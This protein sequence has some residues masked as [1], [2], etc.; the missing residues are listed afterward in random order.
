VTLSFRARISI[1]LVV[2][3]ILPVAAAA[4]LMW[5]TGAGGSGSPG[6]AIDRVVLFGLILAGFVGLTLALVLTSILLEPLKD[7]VKAVEQVSDGEK[8]TRIEVPGEDELALLADRYNRLAADLDLRDRELDRVQDEIAKTDPTIGATRLAELAAAGAK[9]AFDMTSAQFVLGNPDDLPVTD[10]VPGEPLPIRAVL[11]LGFEEFGALVGTLAPSRS[12]KPSD[13]ALLE[14][15]VTEIAFAIRNAELIDRV[16]RQNGRLRD[17]D[18]AKDEF[19]RGVGHNLQTPLTSIRASAQQLIAERP[20]QRLELIDEQAGRLSRMVR[21]L[22]T[23]SRLD[24]GT[25]KA[26]PDVLALGPRATRAWEAL[27]AKG[28][29]FEVVDKAPGWLAVADPDQLDQVLWALLDNAVSHGGKSPVQ[30]RIVAEAGGE[31]GGGAANADAGGDAS[32]D[33]ASTAASG[34]ASRL[35]LTVADNGPGIPEADRERLFGRY[36]QLGGADQR[37][38][39]GLGLY[40]S[41]ELCRAMGGD[42]VLEP[43]AATD[44]AGAPK[45]KTASKAKGRA[46]TVASAAPSGAAFTVSLPAEP[47]TGE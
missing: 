7:F 10:R 33:A 4:F 24:S 46:G 41:R 5:A 16:E 28:V 9:A 37:G 38:G 47:P 14:L 34:A 13:Q 45:P 17:L 39:T 26:R 15:Y 19:L 42:L 23:V 25:V 40:V 8:R 21:Q 44:K 3:A 6:S 31:D 36:E 35:L 30:V 1:A 22:V 2:A 20:D 11:R 27:G 29:P 32:P 18:A 43:A 12:W